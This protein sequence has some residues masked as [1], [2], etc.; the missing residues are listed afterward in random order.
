MSNPI[1]IPSPFPDSDKPNVIEALSNV[2]GAVQEVGKTGFNEQQQFSFR[3]VDAVVNAV[4]P[5]LRTEHVI[6]LPHIVRARYR[7]FNTKSGA[8]MHECTVKVRYTFIGPDGSMLI[9]SA[10][11]ESADSGDKATAKA[12]SVAYRTALIQAL[13]IPTG[14]PDPDSETYERAGTA[15]RSGRRSSGR[16]RQ[17]SGGQQGGDGGGGTPP[18]TTDGEALVA[19]GQAKSIRKFLEQIPEED[20]RARL[21]AAFKAH[22]AVKVAGQLPKARYTEA[23][24]WLRDNA[25]N[26]PTVAPS[27][28]EG[29]REAPTGEVCG[30]CGENPCICAPP[31]AQDDGDGQERGQEPPG[32]PEPGEEPFETPAGDESAAADHGSDEEYQALRQ[33]VEG[34][35]RREI[36]KELANAGLPATGTDPDLIDR[37]TQ[38]RVKAAARK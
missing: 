5:V 35:E 29:G 7:D 8:L 4:G 32:A 23:M 28:A 19:E 26:P 25:E 9:C 27:A 2:M 13:C 24:R 3:G 38:H 12:M 31:D 1:F 15:Q 11:G 30:F 10:P 18:A 22:F 14:E 34:M 16:G 20:R 37:L 36:Q 17:Q 33:A 6:V 21:L